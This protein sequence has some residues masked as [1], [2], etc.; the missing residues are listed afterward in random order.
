MGRWWVKR[1]MFGRI[2]LLHVRRDPEASGVRGRWRGWVGKGLRERLRE[3]EKTKQNRGGH[4]DVEVCGWKKRVWKKEWGFEK[5][6]QCA[7]Q[8][9]ICCLPCGINVN[10]IK[11]LS[12]IVLYERAGQSFIICEEHIWDALTLNICLHG[13]CKILF[14]GLWRDLKLLT[15]SGASVTGP[16]R[17]R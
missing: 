13:I 14:G 2:K 1:A 16:C 5:E 9:K 15:E 11:F 3:R 8:G 12:V 17:C 7:V 10:R 4:R 6:M